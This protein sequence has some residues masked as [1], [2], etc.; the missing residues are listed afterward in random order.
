VNHAR[1][2]WNTS[3]TGPFLLALVAA[4]PAQSGCGPANGSAIKITGTAA[5]NSGQWSDDLFSFALENLNHL[6]DNDSQEMLRST[7]QRL[8]ALKQPKDFPGIVPADNLLASWPEPDML[9]QVVSRLNQWVDTQAKPDP[10][11]PD[12]MLATLPADLASLP[13]LKDGREVHFTAYDGYMLMEAVWLRD[14]ARSKSAGGTSADELLVARSLFDW[15]VRNI[16]TDIDRPDRVPLVPWEVLFFGHGTAW[17]RA[18][19]YILLLRQR[20]IEAAVLALPDEKAGKSA[21]AKSGTG[22]LKPWCVAVLLGEKDKKLYL[23]DPEW[24]LPIAGPRGIV[25]DNLGRLDVEP[26]TLS[27][28]GANPKLLEAMS[29][30]T[31]R[32]YWALKS[33]LKRAVALVEASPLYLEP[34]SKRVESRLSGKLRMVLNA[35]PSQQAAHFKAAGVGEVRLWEQPYTTLKRRLA[36]DTNEVIHRLIAYEPFMNSLL[37]GTVAPLYKGRILHLKGRYFEEREAVAYYQRARPRY[38]DINEDAPKRVQACYEDIT[39]RAK[40]Q[41]GR[42]LN[43]KEDQFCRGEA[44]LLAQFELDSIVQGKLT[45]SYWLGLIQYDAQKYDAAVEYFTVRT[46]QFGPQV[47]W[48]AGAHYNITRCLEAAGRRKEA[49][50]AYESSPFLRN[51]DGNLVRAHWLKELGEESKKAEKKPE[52]KKADEKKSEDK[53]TDEKNAGEKK[54]DE[55]KIMDGKVDDKKAEDKKAGKDH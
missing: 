42:N 35:E 20:G 17:E 46:L 34:R 11:K 50:A 25:A 48:T 45:A 33:D 51:D 2:P 15:T 13:M 14:A 1:L 37:G 32:P 23:F 47:F 8:T 40:E 49:I 9:R 26:A 4:L 54:T 21:S 55:K 12:P 39:A 29:P 52:V 6:E 18:W 24:R 30:T 7:R 28:I 16:Q 41:L 31:D 53:K 10:S 43:P 36:L 3:W 22:P 27:E 19:T 5:E 44:K 38:S